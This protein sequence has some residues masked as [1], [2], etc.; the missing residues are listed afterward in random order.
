MR[1]PMPRSEP[2]FGLPPARRARDAAGTRC[3]IALFAMI[4]GFVFPYKRKVEYLTFKIDADATRV[5]ATDRAATPVLERGAARGEPPYG[6]PLAG[7]SG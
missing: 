4:P 7:R 1:P 3:L 5:F 6:W 2:R